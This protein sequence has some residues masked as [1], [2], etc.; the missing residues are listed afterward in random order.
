MC[1]RDSPKTPQQ[2]MKKVH[3]WKV[4]MELGDECM[5][6]MDITNSYDL[7]TSGITFKKEQ[8]IVHKAGIINTKKGHKVTIDPQDFSYLEV[9]GKGACGIVQKALHKPTGILFAIKSVSYTHLRAHETSLHLVCRLLL[10]KKKNT[11]HKC[12]TL[13]THSSTS[14]YSTVHPMKIPQDEYTPR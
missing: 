13:T 6:S 3:K 4:P 10:E 8:I 5:E 2:N 7:N 9:L 11:K 14:S 1:I 12:G